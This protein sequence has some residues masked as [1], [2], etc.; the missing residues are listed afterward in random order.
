MTHTKVMATL[1]DNRSSEQFIKDLHAAGMQGVRI[2]SAHVTPASI[3]DII[4]KVR[5]V[6]AGITVLMD[7]KGPEMRTTALAYEAEEIVLPLNS[8]V[9][10]SYGTSLSH[11]GSIF[12]NVPVLGQY[13]KPGDTLAVDDGEILLSVLSSLSPDAVSCRVVRQGRLGSRKSVNASESATLPPMPAVSGK[14]IDNIAAAKQCGVDIIAH[15]FVR[16]ADDVHQVREAINDPSVKLFA[17][18]ETR[19][20]LCNLAEIAD[21]AD[22]LLVARGDLGAQI[23]LCEVPARQMHIM[24]LCR[25]LRK[26][27]IIST[28]IL[29]SMMTSPQP[30]RAEVNDIAFGVVQGAD[31]MLLTGET[32]KGQYPVEAVAAMHS[33]IKATEKYLNGCSVK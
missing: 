15:S 16:T 11:A 24:E 12:V 8:I 5:A 29:N 33:T 7:T 18:I 26:P 13:L 2:N 21:A 31:W 17:K 23:A 3:A 10:V 20:A 30:T 32:A 28:Q 27:A 1:A 6:D 4:A 9:S 14:D 19:E 25:S 22:G